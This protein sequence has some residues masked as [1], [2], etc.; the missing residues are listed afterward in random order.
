MS[1]ALKITIN[2]REVDAVFNKAIRFSRDMSFIFKAMK[3]QMIK[4]TTKTFQ[5]E[6]RHSTYT[7]NEPWPSLKESTKK[8]RKGGPPYKILQDTGELKRSI[9]GNFGKDFVEWGPRQ[10]VDYGIYH[11]NARKKNRQ[12][13]FLGFFTEDIEALKKITDI[14]IRDMARKSRNAI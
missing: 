12:R 7:G 8:R 1:K 6:G 9:V 13:K 4:S 3:T 2:S 10:G 14:W 11:Q 5:V